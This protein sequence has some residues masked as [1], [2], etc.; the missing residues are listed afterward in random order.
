M[1]PP[2]TTTTTN[3]PTCRGAPCVRMDER[4]DDERLT[5]FGLIIRLVY[6]WLAAADRSRSPS[7]G[8]SPPQKQSTPGIP[9][10]ALETCGDKSISRARIHAAGLR[11]VSTAAPLF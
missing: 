10:C 7:E 6:L 11:R 1:K 5:E 9:R 3:Q 4:E 2:T 8:V